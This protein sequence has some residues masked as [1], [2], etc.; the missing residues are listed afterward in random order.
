MPKLQELLSRSYPTRTKQQQ[1][2]SLLES[3]GDPGTSAWKQLERIDQVRSLSFYNDLIVQPLMT[4]LLW[5][6]YLFAPGFLERIGLASMFGKYHI[7]MTAFSV[8]QIVRRAYQSLV[9]LE[10]YHE[11]IQQF[12][13]WHSIVRAHQGPYIVGPSKYSPLLYADGIAR[14][15]QTLRS[16]LTQTSS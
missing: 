13:L 16:M 10:N 14:I 8:T 4:L 6:L 3:G 1:V 7:W 5:I 11:S 15:I 12:R 9:A 2:L